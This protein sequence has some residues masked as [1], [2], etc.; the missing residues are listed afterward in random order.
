MLLEQ[1]IPVIQSAD[2]PR[3]C[4]CKTGPSSPA[5][6]SGSLFERELGPRT[7][8]SAATKAATELFKIICYYLSKILSKICEEF[9]KISSNFSKI[10]TNFCIQYSIFQHFSKSTH[11]CKILQKILQHFAKF[12]RIS[13]NFAK[14]CK[15]C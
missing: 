6:L 12:L 9:V 1:R 8:C 2:C 14:F 7:G 4:S 11:F 5:C 13:E 3:R 10:F 15:I